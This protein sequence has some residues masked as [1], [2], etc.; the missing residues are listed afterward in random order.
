VWLKAKGHRKILVQGLIQVAA[1]FHHH[2]HRNPAGFC[3][4]L[5]KGCTKL[6]ILKR[7]TWSK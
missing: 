3:S 2:T 4:L 6:E 1:A 7:R 5:E